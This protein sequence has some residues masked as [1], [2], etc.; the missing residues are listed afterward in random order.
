M[1]GRLLIGLVAILALAPASAQASWIGLY[2]QD[3]HYVQV[4][5]SAEDSNTASD[6]TVSSSEDGSVVYVTDLGTTMQQFPPSDRSYQPCLVTDAHH[7]I[8]RFLG[9]P[10]PTNPYRVDHSSV[11]LDLGGDGPDKVN[12]LRGGDPLEVT[13]M[14]FQDLDVTIPESVRVLIYGGAGDL[15]A[16]IGRER[17]DGG[18]FALGWGKNLVYS[19]NHRVDDIYCPDPSVATSPDQRLYVD[20]TDNVSANCAGVFRFP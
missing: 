1:R 15:T 14:A 19:Y 16:R 8:C 13:A 9:V 18:F 4:V 20:A 11:E 7:A 10:N 3:P 2:S 12:V 17:D 6:V 5:Y